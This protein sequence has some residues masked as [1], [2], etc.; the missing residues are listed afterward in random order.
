MLC[1]LFLLMLDETFKFVIVHESKAAPLWGDACR[2]MR[3]FVDLIPIVE[4]DLSSEYDPVFTWEI[5]R[6]PGT[7]FSRPEPHP[8][9]LWR[10]FVSRRGGVA[11]N[12]P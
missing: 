3:A 9:Q 7:V 10:T 1:P 11:R 5:H 8:E 4:I 12:T 6:R 2:A